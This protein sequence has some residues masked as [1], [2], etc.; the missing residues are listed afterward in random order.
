MFRI[1][2]LFSSL[3]LLVS[4]NYFKQAPSENPVARVNNNYLYQEDINDLVTEATSKEDSAIIVSNYINRW[5]TQQLLLNQ[6]KINLSQDR[7]TSYE[8][9]VEDYRNDL[10]TEAYKGAIVLKQLDSTITSEKIENYYEANKENFNLTETLYKLRYIH[11]DTKFA[12]ISETKKKFT[13]FNT[14]DQ[15]DLQRMSLEFKNVNLNDSIWIKKESV[16]KQLPVLKSNESTALKKSDFKQLEDSLGVYL[17]KI[18]DVLNPNDIAP[19]AYI[20]PTIE[21]IILSKRK[22]ELIKKLEKDIT[23]DAIKN[24]DFEIYTPK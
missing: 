22:L 17:L 8:R 20:K 12:N 23:K 3:L 10:F 18:V 16:L 5:A 13:R 4:C 2:V 11:V 21:E 19:L 15:Q 6:A 14:E 24:K 7:I 9:M 1:T